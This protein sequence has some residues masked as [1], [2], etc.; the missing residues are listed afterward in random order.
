M[1]PY[2][3]PPSARAPISLPSGHCICCKDA[4]AL[5]KQGEGGKFSLECPICRR[6]LPTPEG[7][8]ANR[9][10]NCA[11]AAM[12]QEHQQKTAVGRIATP[13]GKCNFAMGACEEGT[14]AIHYCKACAEFL[15]AECHAAH[16]RGRSTR[17]HAVQ[18]VADMATAS[19]ICEAHPGEPWKLWCDRCDK[20]VCRG[21]VVDHK[22]HTYDSLP[23]MFQKHRPQMATALEELEACL[24]PV[25]QAVATIKCV[26][27]ELTQR[28]DALL[29][30][31]GRRGDEIVAAVRTRIRQLQGECT[32]LACLKADRLI[33]QRMALQTA[34][35]GMR[36][37]CAFAHGA[38]GRGASDP[39]R[40]LYA[41]KQLLGDLRRMRARPLALEPAECARLEFVDTGLLQ[42][43]SFGR[44]TGSAPLA[45]N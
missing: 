41:R 43:A 19:E 2:E 13:E 10:C 12:I 35:E 37:G 33:A 5:Q 11:L 29:T 7:G 39:A 28:R 38:L 44:V 25:E 26:E 40:A 32:E 27:E 21:C 34:L 15:C 3:T 22:D 30:D 20:C 45:A 4:I 42:I 14:A 17:A 16:G 24:P 9:P 8:M 1:E 36:E 6:L 23:A 31:I 18:S